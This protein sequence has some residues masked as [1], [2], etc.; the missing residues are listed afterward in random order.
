MVGTLPLLLSLQVFAPQSSLRPE[1]LELSAPVAGR[2]GEALDAE[3]PR[4][5]VGAPQAESAFVYV[6]QPDGSF[7]LEATLDRGANTTERDAF[8][9]S[10]ALDDSM[11]LLAVGVPGY[12]ASGFVADA[13]SQPDEASGAVMVFERTASV[14]TQTAIVRADLPQGLADFGSAIDLEN[15]RLVV[16]ARLHDATPSGTALRDSGAVYVFELSGAS[17]SQAA[18][19]LSSDLEARDGFGTA[20]ALDGDDLLVG[21]PKK[22][23]GGVR[24]AGASYLFTLQAG[25]WNEQAILLA[26]APTADDAFGEAVALDGDRAVVGAPFASGIE[27]LDG[28]AYVYERSASVWSFDE[29]IASSRGHDA[30][31]FGS[32][33]DVVGSRIAVGAPWATA[34]GRSSGIVILFEEQAGTWMESLVA[35]PGDSAF[36]DRLGTS[37]V[38]SEGAGLE[39]QLWAGAPGRLEKSGA[40][41]LFELPPSFERY[42][43]GDGG[44]GM[45][46]TPCPCGNEA[47]VGSLGGCLNSESR[48][49]RLQARGRASLLFDLLRFEARDLA[50]QTFGLLVS[51]DNPLPLMGPCPPGS[52]VA[53]GVFDGLRCVGGGFLRHEAR[54]TDAQG[55][56][57]VTTPAWGAPDGPLGGLVLSAGLAMV[58]MERS[59]QVFYRDD[60]SEVCGT[61]QNTTQAVR[62]TAIP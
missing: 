18:L 2:F 6:R 43:F 41:S 16:G 35:H 59:F 33:V 31:A 26:P 58:G 54:P 49:G 9:T 30:S 52:G 12:D 46:C 37:V 24:L 4:V 14:W 61:G 56:I 22:N 13:F 42:C 53:G 8:G 10:V 29:T 5:V 38:L 47:A 50:P 11:N 44:D 45:A 1:T 15:G 7:A 3:G 36:R 20:L 32:A 25:S 39:T 34:A 55:D 23:G 17:W 40:A 62:V 21:A 28:A 48:S 27:G 57:G 51:G 19:I 60:P